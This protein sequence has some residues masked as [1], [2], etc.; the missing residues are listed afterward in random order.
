M[1]NIVLHRCFS[2]LSR[3]EK[4]HHVHTLP[5]EA[6]SFNT[7]CFFFEKS[8]GDIL[9]PPKYLKILAKEHPL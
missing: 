1:T 5:L 4:I 3:I 7:P 2:L 9:L 6:S 8:S